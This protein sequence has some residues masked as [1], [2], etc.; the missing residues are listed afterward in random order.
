G[1]AF[2]LQGADSHQLYM[3]P[4]P[5]FSSAEEA[6]EMAELYWMAATRDVSFANYDS[7][8]ATQAAAAE[9]S[10][11]SDF[12]GPKSSARVTTMTLYRGLTLG[13]LAGPY[14]SQFLWQPLPYGAQ[15]IDQRIASVVPHADFV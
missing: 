14:I 4:P 12:R 1:L 3:P 9:L 7:D 5:A 13:D 2:D 6:S 8:L 15:V 11:M 10:R